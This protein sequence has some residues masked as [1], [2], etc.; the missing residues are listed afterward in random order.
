MKIL[1]ILLL[2]P[3]IIYGGVYFDGTDD[4]VNFGDILDF[5]TAPFSVNM[6]IKPATVQND[7]ANIIDKDHTGSKG[8]CFEYD[9]ATDKVYFFFGTAGGNTGTTPITTTGL[10]DNAWHLL[11]GTYGGT[12]IKIYVDGVLENTRAWTYGSSNSGNLLIGKWNTAAGREFTGV[13]DEVQIY[14]I[15]VSSTQ[16]Y[17]YWDTTK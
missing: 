12:E 3:S 5:G 2:I 14:N 10:K 16:V 11:T 13:I 17:N 7:Y 1:L 4:Y 9:I 15:T 6:W 8:W